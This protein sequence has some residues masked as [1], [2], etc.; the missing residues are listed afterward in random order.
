MRRVISARRSGSEL[1]KRG[2]K[3]VFASVK[4]LD[5]YHN[6][7]SSF[8]FDKYSNFNNICTATFL[9]EGIPLF[10]SPVSAAMVASL[11]MSHEPGGLIKST[12]LIFSVSEKPGSV[13]TD[14]I[15]S[16]VGI[17]VLLGDGERRL[18]DVAR[19]LAAGD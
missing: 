7:N 1:F 14:W 15:K 4:I 3:W 9:S 18:A 17:S 12:A 6:N 8:F 13:V 5:L 19:P 16:D 2:I 11:T 10:N